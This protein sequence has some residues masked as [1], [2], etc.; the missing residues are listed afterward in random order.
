MYLLGGIRLCE[1]SYEN[2]QGG[3]EKAYENLHR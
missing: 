3:D 2:L 1:K